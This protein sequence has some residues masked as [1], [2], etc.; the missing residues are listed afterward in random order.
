M[1]PRPAPKL[2]ALKRTPDGYH[3][4]VWIFDAKHPDGGQWQ[5]MSQS[6]DAPPDGV[7]TAWHWRDAETGE[8][9]KEQTQ[10]EIAAFNIAQA[11]QTET[12]VFAIYREGKSFSARLVANFKPV[13]E[14]EENT[15]V[16]PGGNPAFTHRPTLH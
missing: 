10:V 5:T 12:Q 9:L 13:E 16:L 2:N 11:R 3:I 6:V 1:K 14:G 15:T 4:R 7:V 8:V